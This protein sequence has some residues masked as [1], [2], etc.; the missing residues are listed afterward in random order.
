MNILSEE[1]YRAGLME[2]AGLRRSLFDVFQSKLMQNVLVAF[3][4]VD[5]HPCKRNSQCCNLTRNL[6]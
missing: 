1:A 2:V 5:V 4:F 6:A 3:F